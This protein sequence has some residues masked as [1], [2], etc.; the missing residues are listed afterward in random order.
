[1][2][3]GPRSSRP[4]VTACSNRPNAGGRVVGLL[5]AGLLAQLVAMVASDEAVA[6]SKKKVVVEP[7]VGPGADRFR[8]M[9][10]TVLAKQ[11]DVAMIPD[12][13]VAAAQADL[14]LTDPSKGYD[15]LA[16]SLKAGAYVGGKITQVKKSFRAVLVVRDTTGEALSG[17]AWTAKKPPALLKVVG[18]EVGK[19][20]PALL[21][22]YDE[23]L[24]KK[25]VAVASK[26]GDEAEK[27]AAGG[28]AKAEAPAEAEAVAAAPAE[29]EAQEGEA[30]ASGG[31]DA[32]ASVSASR[33]QTG[34]G[35]MGNGMVKGFE[36]AAGLK[37]FNR[38]LAFNQ[39]HDATRMA[40]AISDHKVSLPA[41]TVA[42]EYAP[43][44][45]LAVAAGLDYTKIAADYG[46]GAKYDTQLMA[47]SLGVK[48]RWA[49]GNILANGILAY[50]VQSVKVSP[51]EGDASA[52]KVPGV[53][54]THV[55]V[56]AGG[57][58]TMSPQLA[59]I[60]GLNYLHMLKLGDI[61]DGSDTKTTFPGASALGGEAFG[62]V[63]YTA[64]FM[65]GIEGRIFA[66]YRRVVFNMGSIDDDLAKGGPAAGGAIDQY[67][68]INLTLAYRSPL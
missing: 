46:M 36:V 52:S 18:G 1:M 43:L 19:K 56:G 62:G 68:G 2:K 50:G 64:P 45:Y 29:G 31:D 26:S 32:D 8:Q 49:F 42:A 57:R 10:V 33:R 35:S 4:A 60:G 21:A 61:K 3:R 39:V 44:P 66:D 47:Y 23:E 59:L 51:V 24:A 22:Q 67:I 40:Q 55:K 34:T 13:K 48:P 9:V 6:Q 30:P 15:A 58:Y 37:Y 11:R 63:A 16:K 25:S 7:F 38:N 14:G 20:L 28:K 65:K 12:K 53:A 5:L 27:P 54:Y 41:L 17:T